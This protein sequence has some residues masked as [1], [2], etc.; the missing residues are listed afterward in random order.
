LW[1]RVVWQ[2]RVDNTWQVT[3]LTACSEAR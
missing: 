3:A 1:D 2:C